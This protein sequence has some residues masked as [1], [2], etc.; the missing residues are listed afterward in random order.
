MHAQRSRREFLALLGSAGVG[1][2]AGCS[3]RDAPAE[4]AA[5][6]PAKVAA[7]VVAK[8]VAPPP[9]L[10]ASPGIVKPLPAGVFIARGDNNAETRLESLAQ[11]ALI[12]P[13][14]HFYVRSHGPTP[15]L[16]AATWRLEISG[17]GVERPVTLTYDELTALPSVTITRFIECAGNGR[18]FYEEQL[19]AP[20]EGDPWRHGAFGVATWTGVPLATVLRRAGLRPGAAWVMPV[21][22]DSARFARPMP[23]EKSL[24]DDTLIVH[25]MN[26]EPLPPDHGFPARVLVSGWVGAASVKWL[27]AI[28]V[29]NSE[30]KVET[31]TES[32]VMLGPDHPKPP[33]PLTT[34]RVKS[35]VALPW[36]ATLPAG[37]RTI[38]G[39]AWSP[40]GKIA[41]VEVSVDGG[42]TFQPARLVGD[43]LPLAGTRWQFDL[44]AV[45]GDMFVMSRAVDERGDGQPA[46]A[47]QKWNEKGY[48]FAAPVPH[49]IRVT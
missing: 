2:L 35:A 10:L 9:Q 25:R 1:A 37:K 18:A 7:K 22:L 11:D 24:A 8:V 39:F 32:Y 27:G 17:E 49:P 26:G 44:E 34:L 36:P 15:R 20:A 31:N 4:A 30:P 45:P 46:L 38:S 33:V 47:E 19:A 41:R 12:T 6:P 16:D 28:E 43:N 13:T 21:S 40:S 14:S 3:P 23:L 29:S 5:S 42:L 48:L